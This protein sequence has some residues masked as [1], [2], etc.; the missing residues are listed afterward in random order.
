V[1]KALIDG[2]VPTGFAVLTL[3]AVP[4][5]VVVAVAS[6]RAI[7]SPFLRLRRQWARTSARQE[8]PPESARTTA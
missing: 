7:E 4:I 3:I 5:C 2:G 6:Y 8:P 1:I